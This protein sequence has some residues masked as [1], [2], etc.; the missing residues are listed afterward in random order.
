M[1][2]ALPPSLPRAAAA[3]APSASTWVHEEAR[4]YMRRNIDAWWPEITAGAEAIV[5]TASGCA[6]LVKEYGRLLAQDPT[7]AD[8]AA[9]VSE[10][11]R[12]LSEIIARETLEGKIRPP[13]GAGKIAFHSPCT[14]QHAQKLDGVVEGLLAKS[15]FELAPVADRQLCCG[16][17]GT[18]SILQ[19]ALSNE[20]RDNTLEAL[21]AEGPC[22]IAT[23][24][25]GCLMHLAGHARYPSNTGSNCWNPNLPRQHDR[26]HTLLAD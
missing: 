20:L 1:R 14:L 13:A 17:A 4:D 5:I 8:K 22:V 21:Q 11:A 15:G 18:Y 7:Y 26:H 25:I 3:A 6:A 19:A 12:D 9:R 24:N 23:A 2:S 10:L 16:S